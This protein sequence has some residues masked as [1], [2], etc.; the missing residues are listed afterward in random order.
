MTYAAGLETFNIIWVAQKFNEEHRAALELV[1]ST[2]V[3]EIS[4]FQKKARFVAEGI[5]AA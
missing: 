4:K 1:E 3:W 2:H 5:E